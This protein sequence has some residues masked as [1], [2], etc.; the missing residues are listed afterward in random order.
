MLD[1]FS[2]QPKDQ[3]LRFESRGQDPRTFYRQLTQDDRVFA[4]LQKRYTNVLAG[5][6]IIEPGRRR[7]LSAT[8]ADKK[9]ADMVKAQI[10]EMG[11]DTDFEIEES[12]ATAHFASGFTNFT[13]GMLDAILMGFAVG[14]IMWQRDGSDCVASEVR[15]RDQRRFSFVKDKDVFQLHL[16]NAFGSMTTTPLPPRKFITYTWGSDDDPYGLGLGNRL[17]WPVFF[18][19]KGLSFWATFLEKH[20]IPTVWAK[21]NSSDDT[22]RAKLFNAAK[23]LMSDSVVVTDT[24]D[25][26]ELLEAARGAANTSSYSQLQDAMNKAISI[27]TLGSELSTDI[28]D[29]GSRAATVV[30]SQEEKNLAIKDGQELSNGPY[31]RLARWITWYNF[32]EEV[33]TPLV[34]HRYP[35]QENLDEESRIL[36][37]LAKIGFTASTD[38][39]LKF[40]NDKFGHGSDEPIFE[41][42]KPSQSLTPG[43]S[44]TEQDEEN[45]DR[46]E[47]DNFREEREGTDE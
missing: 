43:S 21:S 27:A 25:V 3:I 35:L 42:E 28:Q 32:T 44:G 36:E 4:V 6:L 10:R 26:I 31:Q 1:G 14:E 18:K 7:G 11:K 40:V 45:R 30:H 13:L 15:M 41:Y 8:R 23:A 22:E 5:D 17:Y 37:R 19:R 34:F 29:G 9:A 24:E 47:E 46:E 38:A 12:V 39:G 16:H 33:A 2:I 20:G